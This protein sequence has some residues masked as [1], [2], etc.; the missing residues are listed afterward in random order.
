MNTGIYVYDVHYS[1]LYSI[2]SSI[3][4]SYKWRQHLEISWV[5]VLMVPTR[6]MMGG[7]G[8]SIT[9]LLI[10]TTDPVPPIQL[11]KADSSL[12]AR[13]TTPAGMG[14]E[15]RRRPGKAAQCGRKASFFFS[16]IFQAYLGVI[17]FHFTW[18]QTGQE[19]PSLQQPCRQD[20]S[21]VPCPCSDVASAPQSVWV[22]RPSLGLG[23][24]NWNFWSFCSISENI[25]YLYKEITCRT[26]QWRGN[27]SPERRFMYW[28]CWWT[29]KQQVAICPACLDCMCPT[30]NPLHLHRKRPLVAQRQQ[31][32]HP[33]TS[34]TKWQSKLN[35]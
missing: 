5:Y 27:L 19:L 11:F 29:C 9:I 34:P 30:R 7:N 12:P 10:T 35:F 16:K 28:L 4:I 8:S 33:M 13:S 26:L 15:F 14:Y 23:R 20:E 21:F 2:Y 25:Y 18:L 1:R 17:S 22:W 32:N 31:H 6:M 24:N 3:S